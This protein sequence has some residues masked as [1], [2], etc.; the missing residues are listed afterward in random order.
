[1]RAKKLLLGVLALG[2]L[3]LGL[4]LTSSQLPALAHGDEEDTGNAVEVTVLMGEM[5]FQVEGQGKN[6]PIV[7]KAGETYELVFKNVGSVVHEA[8]FGKEL[9][10]NDEGQP[11]GYLENLFEGVE[12]KIEGDMAG[13]EFEIEAE[14]LDEIDLSPGDI[15]RVI[16]TLPEEEVGEWEIGCFV[17][18]HY[19]AG[20]KAPIIVE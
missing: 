4:A 1:M 14:S 19:Q 16:V 7:L 5:F 15:L 18:G 9:K 6:E 10:A 12:V 3:A 11:A 2:A 17:P 20:M 8:K 13:G